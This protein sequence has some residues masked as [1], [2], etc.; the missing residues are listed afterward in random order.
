MPWNCTPIHLKP[1]VLS[2]AAGHTH[3]VFTASVLA[4]QLRSCHGTEPLV[5]E[6]SVF[7]SPLECIEKRRSSTS[8][9]PVVVSRLIT[10]TG[11]H[12]NSN[13]PDCGTE[14]HKFLTP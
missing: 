12:F 9:Y 3:F 2:E 11:V 10:P 6:P 7:G 4:S 1:E 14:S 8:I 5:S 13:V